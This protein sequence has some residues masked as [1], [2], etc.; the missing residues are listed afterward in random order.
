MINKLIC[1]Y[2]IDSFMVFFKLNNI[3]WILTA[4]AIIVSIFKSF[5]QNFQGDHFKKI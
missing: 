5:L 4:V 3:N 2:Q 1:S